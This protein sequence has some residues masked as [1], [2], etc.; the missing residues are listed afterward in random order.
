MRQSKI[1]RRVGLRHH[2][3]RVAEELAELRLELLLRL[4][5]HDPLGE[6]GV[7]LLEHA[8][9]AHRVGDLL[10]IA[11]VGDHRS[12][13]RDPVALEELGL[14]DLVRAAQDRDRVVD[15]DEPFGSGATSQPVG[16][17]VHVGR[18]AKEEGIELRD[19]AGVAVVD[20]SGVDSDLPCGADETAQGLRI[21][22]RV[23]RFGSRQD[24]QVVAEAP[25]RGCHTR[26]TAEVRLGLLDHEVAV[27]LRDLTGGDRAHRGQPPGSS[28]P[29]EARAK[30][31]DGELIVER[32]G[33]RVVPPGQVPP[34]VD[35][36]LEART[37]ER[38]E[39]ALD[40]VFE[41]LGDETHDGGEAEILQRLDRGN[42]PVTAGGGQERHVVAEGLVAV[43]AAEVVD[44]ESATLAPIAADQVLP[45]RD[46]FRTVELERPAARILHH[47]ER[48]Q[49]ECPGGSST[50]RFAS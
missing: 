30:Q 13:V 2:E 5:A 37:L 1:G 16:R 6:R 12:R 38:R 50:R 24:R 21:R 18:L 17:V 40:P 19:P 20:L 8:G 45:G 49:R 42:G 7:R 3:L 35:A 33:E 15:H 44:A 36:E 27:A 34:E 48:G 11:I 31:R 26:P 23:G 4:D 32:P 29:F 9:E 39:I 46:D 47:Q 25:G 14:E 41:L 22:G 28:L 43:G 10:G